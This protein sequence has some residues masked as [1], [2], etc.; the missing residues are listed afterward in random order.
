MDHHCAW[1]NNCVGRDSFKY[2][3]LYNAY[4]IGLSMFGIATIVMNFMTVNK[5]HNDG[6]QA[7]YSL[8]HMLY[9]VSA[10]IFTIK[11]LDYVLI[12]FSMWVYLFTGLML[13]KI[14]INLKTNTSLIEKLN[15][16]YPQRPNRGWG[17]AFE[18]AL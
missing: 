10:G 6:L 18:L 16:D 15:A 7:V 4:A 1:T 13:A 8:E 9:E 14:L 11:I 5:E 3:I 2:F 12:M 17:E